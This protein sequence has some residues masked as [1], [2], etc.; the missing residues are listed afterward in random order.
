MPGLDLN[1]LRTSFTIFLAAF[2]TAFISIPENI[3]GIAAPINAPHSVKG[4]IMFSI[5]SFICSTVII[6]A[7]NK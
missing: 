3:N 6:S 1:C 4:F 2:A 5:K 7:A